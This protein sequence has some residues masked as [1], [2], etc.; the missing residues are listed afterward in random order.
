MI[1]PAVLMGQEVNREG[2][3]I[4]DLKG[5]IPHSIQAKQT[6]GAEKIIEKFYT[7]EGGNVAR[8][9]GNGK[10]FAFAID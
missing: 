2:F 8:I 7:H 5:L 3:P 10:T 9:R 6:D 4:P 1:I